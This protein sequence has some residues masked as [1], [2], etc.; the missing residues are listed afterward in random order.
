MS[1]G[2]ATNEAQARIDTLTDEL[3]AL[4]KAKEIMYQK[5][6]DFHAASKF[7][8]A[9][10]FLQT[11]EL[12][13]EQKEPHGGH[14]DHNADLQPIVDKMVELINSEQDKRVTNSGNYNSCNI[15]I[16]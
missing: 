6:A 5:E 11:S 10:F 14:E 4:S 8:N 13:E 2:R 12:A 1:C 3:E 9:L 7:E 15:Q 16:E